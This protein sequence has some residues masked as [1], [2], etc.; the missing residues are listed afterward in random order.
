MA[1][2]TGSLVKQ[3][4]VTGIRN[5]LNTFTTMMPMMPSVILRDPP[6][7]GSSAFIGKEQKRARQ[8]KF[9]DLVQAAAVVFL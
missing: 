8:R 7:D 3:G 6:G 9:P 2:R 4:V 1:G 5:K